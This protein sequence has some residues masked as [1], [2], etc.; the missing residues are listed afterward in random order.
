MKERKKGE[1]EKKGYL[2]ELG[3]PEGNHDV[4]EKVEG[5]TVENDINNTEGRTKVRGSQSILQILQE[6]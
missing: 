2:R 6:G 4:A 1:R 5:T 3:T